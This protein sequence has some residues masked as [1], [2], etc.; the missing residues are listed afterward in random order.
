[1]GGGR[2]AP[3]PSNIVQTW[4][5]GAGTWGTGPSFVTARRNFPVDT[6]GT[7]IILTG[8]YAPTAATN[9]TEI[10]N[11]PV[12]CVGPTPSAVV[13]IPATTVATSTRTA[14]ASATVQASATAGTSTTPVPATATATATVCPAQ[15]QDVPATDPFYVFIR[16]L[17]CRG[18]ISGYTCG[19]PGEPCVPPNNYPYFRTSSPVTRGQVAKMVSNSAP[20]TQPI[21]ST[22]QTFADVPYG[23][24][25]WIWT[26]RLAGM[27]Y[28]SG[29][30]CGGPGEPCDAQNRPYYRP[31]TPVT[32][33]QLAK[34]VSNAA[35]FNDPIPSTQQTFQDVPHS[36][37]FWLWIERVAMHGVISGYGCGGPGEPCVPPGNRPYYRWGAPATRGQTA[38]IVASAFFPGCST[39]SRPAMPLTS[40]ANQ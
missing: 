24:P 26:E 39:P 16:C 11:I 34:I 29:Y 22:Q 23:S 1:M 9:N 12:Q 20:L 17:V 27:G 15:F 33:G 30:G 10:Y 3:N 5:P 32:R 4:T 2:E 19:G 35:L 21:P 18:I 38:K 40:G 36:N 7:K 31:N 28:I 14:V 25:F 6:T 8:G 37:P 13:T